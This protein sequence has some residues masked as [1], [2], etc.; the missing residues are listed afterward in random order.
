MLLLLSL[1]F[2]SGCGFKLRGTLADA[3]HLPDIYVHSE[4][5]SQLSVEVNRVFYQAGIDLNDQRDAAGWV[6]TLSDEQR[7]RR[8]L[9]VG[10]RG[11]VQEYELHYGL[12][13]SLRN[14]DGD[15][16]ID[17]QELT[18]LRDFSFTGAD[19]LA[20]ADEEERLYQGMQTQAAQLIL[21]RLLSL[22]QRLDQH[23]SRDVM[24]MNNST[25]QDILP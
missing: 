6:L 23:Q 13:Y 24:K 4:R 8:V 15:L 10:R 20:K 14:S 9:S 7:Q 2:V 19:V 12:N 1:L 11:K 21:W 25:E 5:G 22:N 16:I 18:L 17:R 3:R